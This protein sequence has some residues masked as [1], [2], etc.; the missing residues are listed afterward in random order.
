MMFSRTSAVSSCSMERKMGSRCVTVLSWPSSG[1]RPM[2]TEARATFTCWLASA[3]SGRTMGSTSL[4][5][6][7][8]RPV[9][10]RA[11]QKACSLEAATSRTSPSGSFSR[12][13]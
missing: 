3:V 1:A 7:S 13:V 9:S 11:E 8:L 2:I 12:F 6:D 10:G 4:M 5:M